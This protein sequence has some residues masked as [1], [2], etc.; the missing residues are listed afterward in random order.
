MIGTRRWFGALAGTAAILA[1][2]GPVAAQGAQEINLYSSRHYNTD[3]ALYE[4]FTKQTGIRINLVEAG[5]NELIQ[6]LKTEGRNSPADVV[7]TVDAGRLEAM[8]ADGLFQPVKSPVL[9][10][11]IPKHLQDP[12]GLWYG[13]SKRARVLVYAKDRVK[14]EQLSTYE[15]LAD[16]AWKGKLLIRSS[17]NVY[18][19][20]LM[21]SIIAADGP[22]KA[23]AWAKGIVANL[24]RPP[25]GGDTDQLKGLA[26]GEGDVA[27]SNTYYVARLFASNKPEDKAIADKIAVFFPNQGDRGTHVNVSG[28]G[29][30][31]HAPNKAGAIKFLEYLSSPQAQSYFA[32]GNFEYP[33]VA[34]SPMSPVI[35]AWGPFKEDQLNAA[36]F[37][38]N[39]R[40]A[41]EI[42][43]RAGWK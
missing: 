30:A 24:A 43:D 12:T 20:S 11:A 27:V 23:E 4:T 10:Q 6:R 37:A 21:G 14:P 22:E 32:E 5:E 33:V 29:V 31:A 8:A 41:L 1:L 39:A 34:E 15:Q 35:A 18:N 42:M 40:Q 3:R 2:A 16:P 9:D 28:A 25:R 17:T 13:F 26:A 38:K 19:L 36:T 7:I